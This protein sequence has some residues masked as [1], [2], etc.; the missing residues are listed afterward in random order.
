ML[1]IVDEG[2]MLA[3]LVAGDTKQVLG[4]RSMSPAEVGGLKEASAVVTTMTG[5][6]LIGPLIKSTN[7]LGSVTTGALQYSDR[8]ADLEFRA[9][10][11]MALDEWLMHLAMFRRRTEREVGLA[12]GQSAHDH[13]ASH[14]QRLYDEHPEFRAC[15]DWR[16]AAQHHVNPLHITHLHADESNFDGRTEW[17][18]APAAVAATGYGWSRIARDRLA[19]GPSVWELVSSAID[20]CE[21]V[22]FAVI[23]HNEERIGN[24]ADL[25]FGLCREVMNTI[26][27]QPEGPVTFAAFQAEADGDSLVGLSIHPLRYDLA[28]HALLAIDNA[29]EHFGEPRK[30]TPAKSTPPTQ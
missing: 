12:L 26:D 28:S 24:A 13:A 19:E 6:N 25:I 18:I 3:R 20:A 27:E 9:E 5:H 15:W 10:W 21:R 1:A 30:W 29:R 14:F 4:I 11:S 17:S 23:A 7:R 2:W 16:N 22:L 8:A